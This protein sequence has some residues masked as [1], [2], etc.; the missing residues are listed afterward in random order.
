MHHHQRKMLTRLAMTL[1]ISLCQGCMFNPVPQSAAPCKAGSLCTL[2][3]KLVLLPGAPAGAA[4]VDI[5]DECVKLA[6]PDEF[7]AEPVRS[8]WNGR[9]VTVEGFAFAQPDSNIDGDLLTWYSEKDRRLAIGA[10]DNGLGIYVDRMR[11]KAGRTWPD[12]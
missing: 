10:C 6:L 9:K 4:I 1:A 7:Y 8:Q 5:G 2:H 3:G 12:P 11:A